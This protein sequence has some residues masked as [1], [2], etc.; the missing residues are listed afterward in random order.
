MALIRRELFDAE[1]KRLWRVYREGRGD[2]PGFCDDYAFFIHGLLDLYEA[3]FDDQYLEFA[4]ILQSMSCGP[5]D[6]SSRLLM[7][8]GLESQIALFL[9]PPNPGF[10]STPSPH[11]PDLLLR[12]KNGQ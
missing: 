11:P 10:Y 4:D 5:N 3:T 1:S 8:T 6:A 9:S 2:A 7:L 12:L